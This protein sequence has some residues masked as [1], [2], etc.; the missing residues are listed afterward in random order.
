MFPKSQIHVVNF[1]SYK[2]SEL[3]EVNKIFRF[4]HR[5]EIF[6]DESIG[7]QISTRHVALEGKHHDAS[8]EMFPKTRIILENFYRPHNIK[9][10]ELLN[11]DV[12]L[13]WNNVNTNPDTV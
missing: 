5:R 1:E 3:T 6:A 4:L 7:K 10:A 2:K 11:D 8:G 12:Y 9:L 13:S